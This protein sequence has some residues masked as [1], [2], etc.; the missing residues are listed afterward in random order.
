MQPVRLRIGGDWWDSQIYAGTLY[1][2]R[3]DGSVVSV[4]WPRLIND[5]VE[6]HQ[7][8]ELGAEL[9]FVDARYLYA[10][11]WSRL[12]QDQEIADVLDHKFIRLA[13]E[14]LEIGDKD[15]RRARAVEL[16]R[17]APELISDAEIHRNVVSFANED[18][19]W[20]QRRNRLTDEEPAVQIWDSSVFRVR[21]NRGVLALAAG[22]EGLFQMRSRLQPET[23]EEPDP[24]VH[25]DFFSCGW[26][27]TN[28][29][30]SSYEH[31]GTLSVFTQHREKRERIVRRRYEAAIP[32]EAIFG[33]KE[34]LSK[35]AVFASPPTRGE[36]GL[37]EDTRDD[38]FSVVFER[39]GMAP[40]EAA[41]ATAGLSWGAQD[42][43]CQATDQGLRVSQYLTR[44]RKLA[45][46]FAPVLTR[47]LPAADSVVGGDVA[48]FGVV[49]E[50]DTNLTVLA[51]EGVWAVG[52][53]PQR[54]RSFGRSTNYPNHLHIVGDGFVD[55]Y[56]FLTSSLR[57][58]TGVKRPLGRTRTSA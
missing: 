25:G 19:L 17:V 31:A 44:R 47:E 41:S 32:D 54:W 39:G 11:Q 35:S 7:L 57:N 42:L 37:H 12:V 20:A 15:L 45:D 22:P 2:I 49:V 40:P 53:E 3:V 58:L 16:G 29:Y 21:A 50:S 52:F 4:H 5:L 51:D 10:G 38:E 28:I 46:R 18:G 36:E 26:V 56:S 8:D 1:L 34:L 43:I 48:P 13:E 6:K 33:S 9:A 30:G 27:G 23:V 55:I 14:D 24:L